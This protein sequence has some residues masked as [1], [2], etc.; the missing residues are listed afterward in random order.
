M[1]TRKNS[2]SSSG[3]MTSKTDTVA[4]SSGDDGAEVSEDLFEGAP[5]GVTG[6]EVV[7]L[8][9]VVSP[10][11]EWCDV[12]D[13]LGAVVEDKVFVAMSSRDDL[14]TSGSVEADGRIDGLTH[15]LWCVAEIDL[16]AIASLPTHVESHRQGGETSIAITFVHNLHI[17]GVGGVDNW[18][19][20]KLRNNRVQRS[21]APTVATRN[22]RRR[23][24]RSNLVVVVVVVDIGRLEEGWL[25]CKCRNL[26]KGRKKRDGT[27]QS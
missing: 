23:R 19:A 16:F 26:S 4:A 21:A 9:V 17:F 25:R 24:R 15:A 5:V 27:N 8:G 6:A 14:E 10:V 20:I 3:N 13:S 2:I 1:E 11:E 22:S 18:I 12:D 7:S